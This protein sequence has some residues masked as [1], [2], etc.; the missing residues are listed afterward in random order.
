MIWRELCET[1]DVRLYTKNRFFM[2]KIRNEPFFFP[3][4]N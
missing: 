3:G 2:L 4:F 1:G